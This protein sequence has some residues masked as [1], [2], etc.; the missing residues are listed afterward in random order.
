MHSNKVEHSV[1]Q[2]ET[3]GDTAFVTNHFSNTFGNRP[4]P[5]LCDFMLEIASYVADKP[6]LPHADE[7]LVHVQESPASKECLKLSEPLMLELL[8]AFLTLPLTFDLAGI[9]GATV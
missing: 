3:L 5:Y 2:H 8:F 7:S 6:H 4:I 1:F 9:D